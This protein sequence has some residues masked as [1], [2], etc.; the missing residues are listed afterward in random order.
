MECFFVSTACIGV[1]ICKF[2]AM[3]MG[4][5][6]FNCSLVCSGSGKYKY[7]KHLQIR[8]DFFEV[9]QNRFSFFGVLIGS[10]RL[11]SFQTA[12]SPS[13]WSRERGKASE[14]SESKKQ[15]AR[16][17]RRFLIT[18]LFSLKKIQFLTARSSLNI[19]YLFNAFICNYS[20]SC[21]TW[22]Y[23]LKSK[24]PSLVIL[25]IMI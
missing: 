23:N 11:R 12:S 18:F 6:F 2:L 7:N 16:S 8:T 4:Q 14:A 13:G 17:L 22:I 1:V 20:C 15:T 19:Q 25:L 5:V 10:N 24:L 21:Y 3:E 9:W